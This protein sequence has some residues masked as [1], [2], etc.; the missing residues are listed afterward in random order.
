MALKWFGTEVS[1]RLRAAQIAGVNATMAAAAVHAKR[2][3]NWQN[4]S[5]VLE[6]SIGIHDYARPDGNG[7]RGT[8][9]SADVVYA[10]IHELGGTIVPKTAK[11]LAIPQTDGSVRLVQSVTIPARPYLRPAADAEYPGLAGR[12]RRAYEAGGAR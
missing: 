4:R 3:H 1:K 6:G 7:V 10:L 11:A 9:G 5:G 12:I 8:W 2:N